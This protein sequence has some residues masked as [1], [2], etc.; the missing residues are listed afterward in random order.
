MAT[1]RSRVLTYVRR[2]NPSLSTPLV[3]FIVLS[4]SLAYT[5]TQYNTP[6]QHVIVVVQENRTPDNLFQDQ[7]LINKGAEVAQNGL[8]HGTVIPLTPFELNAC[9]DPNHSHQPG[10]LKTYDKGLMD[11][12]CD[13][14]T[15]YNPGCVVPSCSDTKYQF[16][17]QYTYVPNTKY[18]GVHGILDPYYQVAE[19]YGFANYMFQTNQGPS[20]PAHQFLFTGTSAPAPYPNNYYDWF[21]AEN[22]IYPKIKGLQAKNDGC[23]SDPGGIVLDIDPSGKESAAFAPPPALDSG[24]GPGFPCYDHQTMPDLL[25]TANPP[26]T[27]RYYGAVEASSLWN[28]PNAISHICVPYPAVAGNCTGPDWT[29]GNVVTTSGQVLNDLQNCTLP[30]VNWVIPDG[31]WSDHP[32]GVNGE[33]AGPSWIAAIVNAVG[34]STCASPAANWSNTAIVIT[35][36]DWGGFYDHVNPIQQVGQ[37]YKGGNGNGK[38]YVYGFRVPL[39]VVSTYTKGAGGAGYISN[40]NHDF[41][42]ILNFIEYAFGQNGKPVGMIGPTQYPYADYFAPDGPF[43]D[44]SSPYSLS[45]FFDFSHSQ[46]FEQINGAKYAPSCF[47]NP[48]S[49]FKNFPTDPDNDAV[50]SQEEDDD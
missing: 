46:P 9:F 27:W 25:A 47:T 13:T 28:A 8:C 20:F 40:V 22:Q 41:G 12:A 30:Q 1:F 26:I 15:E 21:V 14:V 33:P 10:W 24:R 36:D 7:V 37:G 39:I 43:N 5:Q 34:N 18:D 50:S 31:N 35:W 29:N 11:G 38:Q 44:P 19:Q 48:K 2:L 49:C 45:D 4:A 23:L 32:G 16:C 6:F 17:P 42:S 3:A